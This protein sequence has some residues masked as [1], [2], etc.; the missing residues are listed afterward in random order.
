MAPQRPEAVGPE[1]EA[2]MV[3]GIRMGGSA[4]RAAVGGG[5]SPRVASTAA[6]LASLAQTGGASSVVFIPAPGVKASAWSFPYKSGRP[7]EMNIP[8]PPAGPLRGTVVVNVSGH[9][10]G[11]VADRATAWAEQQLAARGQKPT[12]DARKFIALRAACEKA[13]AEL[14]ADKARTLP[15]TTIVAPDGTRLDLPRATFEKMLKASP[16]STDAEAKTIALDGDRALRKYFAASNTYHV[17]ARLPDGRT[18]EWKDVPRNDPQRI[19]WATRIPVEIPAQVRGEVTLECWP[20]G[21][22][23]AGG[24]VEQRQYRIHLGDDLFDPDDATLDADAWRA[25]HRQVRWDTPFEDADRE[26]HGVAPAPM[27]RVEQ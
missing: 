8:Q 12:D 26:E 17:T 6:S 16:K 1:Q 19:E 2:R 27:P 15:G 23:K 3:F 10:S 4:P 22:M 14:I 9:A 25:Q 21:S 20:T 18:L 24:Y 13:T 11:G 5:E 7:K